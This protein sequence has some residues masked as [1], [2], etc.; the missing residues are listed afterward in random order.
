L[1]LLENLQ[2]TQMSEAA[3]KSSAECESHAWPDGR[4]GWTFVQCLLRGMGV[5]RHRQRMTAAECFS[6]GPA[7]LEKQY[8]CTARKIARSFAKKK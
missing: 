4:D 3:R 5:P 7:V 1:V 8:D 6:Y 2:N